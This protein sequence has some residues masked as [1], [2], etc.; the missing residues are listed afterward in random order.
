MIQAEWVQTELSS[1]W[2][3]ED[4]EGMITALLLEVIYQKLFTK[5]GSI[6]KTLL[7]H[8]RKYTPLLDIGTYCDSVGV[9]GDE[10]IC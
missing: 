6:V 4:I 9:K 10:V 1:R 2:E 7:W 3:H 5:L 8:G